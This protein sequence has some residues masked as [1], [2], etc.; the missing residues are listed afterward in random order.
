MSN[1]SAALRTDGNVSFESA[2]E[3]PMSAS[4]EVFTPANFTHRGVSADIYAAT[5]RQAGRINAA[6]V[7]QGE[8]ESLLAERQKLLDKKF[9]G[10]M[11]RAESNR[12]QLV[13]WSLDRIEDAR[14]GLEL[15]R[16][17]S[18]VSSLESFQI[19]VEQL[20]KD[21]LRASKPGRRR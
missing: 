18:L 1:S 12:L 6:N 11:T 7:S 20:R 2:A 13:N 9:S 21:L 8:Y 19:N 4:D 5:A 14:H 10:E 3:S 17:E 16:L 15:E